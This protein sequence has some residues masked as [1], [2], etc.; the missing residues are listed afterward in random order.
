MREI[1]CQLIF[2]IILHLILFSTSAAQVTEKTEI[3]RIISTLAA[4]NMRGRSSLSPDI[5]RAADFIAEE[6]RQGGLKPYAEN[7][8]RQTFDLTK[9]SI[10]KESVKINGAALDAD[11]YLILNN[12]PSLFWNHASRVEE[13]EIKAG[14]DFS[15]RFRDIVRNNPAHSIIW[16]DPSFKSML[17]RFKKILSQESII[18]KQAVSANQPSKVFV[19]KKKNIRHFNIEAATKHEDIHLFNVAAIVPGKSKADEFVVFSAHYDHIGILDP[20]GKDSIA[21]GADDDASGTTAMILLAKYFREKNINERTLI[22]VA[23]TAEEIGMFGSKY[24][25]SNIDADK[26]VAMINIEM[27]GKGSRFGPRTLYVTGYHHSNLAQLMQEKVDGT[28]FTFHADP[29]PQQNLFYRS[30]NA[31][32][33]ALGVPAHTFSTSQIDK[34]EY[35]HT[36]KDEISTL[37][38]DNIKSSIDAIA[39]GVVG[40]ISGEQTPS[41]IEKLTD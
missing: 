32:L 11:E 33:A 24:F 40:V 21:N 15:E 36:V 31:V 2:S 29:Y 12:S 8:Y 27:I 34:D 22:F 26:V 13:V 3:E 5:A 18:P 28:G 10:E 19:I 14:E 37:D 39:K 41:R 30:D 35:Y 9:V 25:S 20:V 1:F 17:V 38:I 23:F 16:V 6:F 4:D 7:N